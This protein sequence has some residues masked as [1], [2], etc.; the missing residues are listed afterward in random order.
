M[1]ELREAK[2]KQCINDLG[3]GLVYIT[4]SAGT[5]ARASRPIQTPGVIR[6]STAN[7]KSPTRPAAELCPLAS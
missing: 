6:G 5:K 1:K 4:Y 3:V 7:V 2:T